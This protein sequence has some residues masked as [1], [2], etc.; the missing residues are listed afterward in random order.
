MTTTIRAILP[1]TL[2]AFALMASAFGC[3]VETTDPTS[4]HAA[5]LE[6]VDSW[7]DGKFA[8]RLVE[9]DGE[10]RLV[11]EAGI[12]ARTVVIVAEE[13]GTPLAVALTEDG[14]TRRLDVDE[15]VAGNRDAAAAERTDAHSERVLELML[16]EPR[17]TTYRFGL[18]A[19]PD[20]QRRLPACLG[21]LWDILF[22]NPDLQSLNCEL[23]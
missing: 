7:S 16:Q 9:L 5:D 8:Y 21:C 6:T 19:T 12:D 22:G 15:L 17:L 13:D 2:L 20:T 14:S 18:V 3:D 11:A 1:R 10:R 23:C 4:L